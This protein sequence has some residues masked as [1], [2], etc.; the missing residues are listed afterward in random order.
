MS[1]E[2]AAKPSR[3]ALITPHFTVFFS[4]LCIMVVELVASRLIARHLGSSL[5]TWTSVIGIVL[6]GIAAGNYIGGLIAD[7]YKPKEALSS[8]FLIASATCLTIPLLNDRV[9]V[10]MFMRDQEWTLR[11]ALHVLFTFFTPAAVLGMIS[12]VAAKMAIQTSDRLGRTVGSVYSWGAVGS[13]VGTF[14]T[15]FFLIAK[16]GTVTTLLFVSGALLLMA[17]Y[18]GAQSLLPYIWAGVL[19][20]SLLAATG[21]W[22]WA[23][24]AGERLGFRTSQDDWVF[25]EEESNYSY[26]RIEEELDM[27]DVRSMTLDY[28][29]HAYIALYDPDDLQYDYERIY[30]G[31]TR[32][33]IETLPEG[34]KARGFFLG[35]GG[36]VFPA[37]V[38]RHYPGS[39]T[40]VA[41]IDPAV[42]RAAFDAF[43]LEPD[44]QMKIYNLDARNHVDDLLLRQE[45]GEHVGNFDLVYGDAF[46][47]YSPPFHLTTHEFNEKVRKLMSDEGVFLAN[48]IDIYRS[49][50][51][52]GAM[53]NTL[54]RTFPHVYVFC[55]S[56]GGPSDEDARDTFVVVGS[57]RLL[58]L[59]SLDYDQYSAALLEPRHLDVI[60]KRSNQLV[61]TDDYAPV[62]NLLAPVIR[63]AEKD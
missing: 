61:L 48:V 11:I 20:A 50:K 54:E 29:I 59:E 22:A 60:R 32:M 47:H 15:G 33:A 14:L 25:F 52:L 12:P 43:G 56:L 30:A 62:D 24:T 44:P 5:Y 8:L 3:L 16:M 63:L 21:P 28:L 17:F 49:A 46:S 26:I 45:R 57:T 18:F 6:A 51:F 36:F 4:S 39:Y 42:T 34:R 23:M 35:G 31:V 7:R 55:T 53:V 19:G 9:G 2:S 10:W 58:D 41:E 40:E 27:P 1:T 13:I 38:L 37:W